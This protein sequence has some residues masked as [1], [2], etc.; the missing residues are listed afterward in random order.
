[1]S[2]MLD[3]GWDIFTLFP[4]VLQIEFVAPIRI[5]GKQ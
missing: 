2:W 4:D 5:V 3:T 1:M